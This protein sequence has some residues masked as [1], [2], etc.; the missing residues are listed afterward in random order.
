MARST[1]KAKGH[2]R[3]TNKEVALVALYDLDQ[4]LDPNLVGDFTA[5]GPANAG[6]YQSG[7]GSLFMAVTG[8]DS[9]GATLSA[10]Q[11]L[12]LL[13]WASRDD[14]LGPVITQASQLSAEEAKQPSQRFD[15]EYLKDPRPKLNDL[16]KTWL[17]YDA[18]DRVE[19][20]LTIDGEVLEIPG[21][22]K[23]HEQAETLRPMVQKLAKTTSETIERV[24]TL[25]ELQAKSVAEEV[26]EL[27]SHDKEGLL[28]KLG[29][30][31]DLLDA[32]DGWLTLSDEKFLKELGEIRLKDPRLKDV[33]TFTELMKAII[34]V[35][36]GV[37]SFKAWVFS[38][39][40]RLLG[41][42][43]LAASLKEFA[44][45]VTEKLGVVVAGIEIIHGYAVLLDSNSTP[46]QRRDAQLSVA[47][48]FGTLLGAAAG[49]GAAVGVAIGG[50]AVGTIL[51]PFYILDLGA[52]AVK[53][54]SYGVL[55]EVFQK[56]HED[57]AFIT[58]KADT[59]KRAGVIKSRESNSDKVEA[60]GLVEQGCWKGGN[61]WGIGTPLVTVVDNIIDKGD[62]SAD[63]SSDPDDHYGKLFPVIAEI[64]A[65]VLSRKG[66]QTRDDALA[67]AA[68]VLDKLK[69]CLKYG[70]LIADADFR[71][72]D[73]AKLDEEMRKQLEERNDSKGE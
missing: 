27:E 62:P 57:Y 69:L 55:R 19:S 61:N 49:A 33:A 28:K 22:G 20:S 46:D 8:K 56:M 10:G 14:Q 16:R 29:H 21:E 39:L 38:G 60:L 30:V 65:P 36:G 37:I 73:L 72:E 23:A 54:I 48:A 2:T 70:F 58:A 35:V 1:V 31:K 63:F 13:D 53:G 26:E 25:T 32:V 41:D 50:A 71:H 45:N 6:Q 40:A 68:A 43:A 7:L 51:L 66:A 3:F 52:G 59:V 12:E 42:K 4:I 44:G 34:G 67:A 18:K 9:K 24:N 15:P 5:A 64:F 17:N 11:R 47:L